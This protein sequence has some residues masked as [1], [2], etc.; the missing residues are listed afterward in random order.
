MWMQPVCCC[1]VLWGSC[2]QHLGGCRVLTL[3][4]KS[5]GTRGGGGSLSVCVLAC[6]GPLVKLAARHKLC[7]DVSVCE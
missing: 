4:I 1:V 6:A 3:A 2:A 7:H 5:G